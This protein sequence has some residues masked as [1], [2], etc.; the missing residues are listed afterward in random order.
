MVKRHGLHSSLPGKW[1]IDEPLLPKLFE[2]VDAPPEEI[3]RRLRKELQTTLLDGDVR[4]SWSQAIRPSSVDFVSIE[5]FNRPSY[6]EPH[7]F[8]R[9]E[10]ISNPT[11]P[12]W[13]VE[14]SANKEAEKQVI[15]GTQLHPPEF[16]PPRLPRLRLHS[17]RLVEAAASFVS[18]DLMREDILS[19][20]LSSDR[21]TESF[22][23]H[24]SKYQE[25]K[26][27]DDAQSI[28]EKTI[29][30]LA[31]AL[32][33]DNFDDEEQRQVFNVAR[34]KGLAEIAAEFDF[35]V[36]WKQHT[37]LEQERAIE[38]FR[39]SVLASVRDSVHHQ[40]NLLPNYANIHQ[41][42]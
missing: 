25:R 36:A 24:L 21:P 23:L 41:G 29:P 32:G 9:R 22:P 13:S 12:P 40:Y 30:R 18:E 1:P 26:K 11:R 27:D 15:V 6:D 38:L 39:E 5:S 37:L 4:D 19:H 3:V 34:S 31:R 14:A 33:F 20:S 10:L 8:D 7:P 35:D 2:Q 28:S 17:P 42:Y 16:H